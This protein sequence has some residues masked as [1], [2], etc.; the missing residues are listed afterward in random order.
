MPDQPAETRCA[1]LRL[2]LTVGWLIVAFHAFIYARITYFYWLD[3][4]PQIV[5]IFFCL[6]AV[7]GCWRKWGA[8]VLLPLAGFYFGAFYYRPYGYAHDAWEAMMED[9][10]FRYS[11][12]SLASLLARHL[13]C[14]ARHP[15]SQEAVSPLTD[16]KV[17]LC[18]ILAL[19]CLG[20]HHLGRP[21]YGPRTRPGEACPRMM[22][23]I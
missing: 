3:T 16:G 21:A 15:R 5:V 10:V 7:I 12:P 20:R 14:V 19:A 2:W 13:S 17:R 8:A 4:L 18:R 23:K 11:S 22:L 9:I 6:L 1:N